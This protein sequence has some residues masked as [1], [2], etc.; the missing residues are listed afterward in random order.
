[1]DSG[2]IVILTMIALYVC[3]GVVLYVRAKG[4]APA[5]GGAEG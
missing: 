5:E 2:Y 4:T 3:T 1:M